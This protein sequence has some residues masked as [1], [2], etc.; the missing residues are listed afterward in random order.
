MRTR[1]YVYTGVLV[2][3]RRKYA[4]MGQSPSQSAGGGDVHTNKDGRTTINEAVKKFVKE[5]QTKL[6]DG[7][8]WKSFEIETVKTFAGIEE[9]VVFFKARQSRKEAGDPRFIHDRG[10]VDSTQ[11]C[12]GV[13]DIKTGTLIKKIKDVAKTFKPGVDVSQVDAEALLDIVG[14]KRGRK[15]IK[16][17][18]GMFGNPGA[19]PPR[20]SKG[21]LKV[22]YYSHTGM[23]GPVFCS[24][25]L[26]LPTK[27]T[28]GRFEGTGLLPMATL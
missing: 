14:S 28:P 26:A 19:S 7:L 5:N 11:Y 21:V 18:L 1:I 20:F 8:K 2:E 4:T 10:T 3:G 12:F 25:E 15:V 27:D 9:G 22:D 13:L 6:Q 23:R 24:S 17:E 16:R